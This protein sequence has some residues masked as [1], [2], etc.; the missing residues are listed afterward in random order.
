MDN[1]RN[2]LNSDS[3]PVLMRSYFDCEKINEDTFFSF[4][5][6]LHLSLN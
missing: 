1:F 3:A 2:L 6:N 4:S 5:K